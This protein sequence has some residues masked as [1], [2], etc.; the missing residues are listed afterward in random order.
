M[1]FLIQC[2]IHTSFSVYL[3]LGMFLFVCVFYSG[4][5]LVFP[6]FCIASVSCINQ[7]LCSMLVAATGHLLLIQ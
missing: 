1:S 2:V 4:M 6:C 7:A 3:N 5:F